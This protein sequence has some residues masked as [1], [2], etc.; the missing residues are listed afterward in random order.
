MI[1]KRMGNWS[2]ALT[3][4]EYLAAAMVGAAQ[5][6]GTSVSPELKRTYDAMLKKQKKLSAKAH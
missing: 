2:W 4:A 1:S 3:G 5:R 6:E